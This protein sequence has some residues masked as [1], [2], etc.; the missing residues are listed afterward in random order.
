MGTFTQGGEPPASAVWLRAALASALP[1][2][3]EDG[4]RRGRDYRSQQQAGKDASWRESWQQVPEE[5]GNKFNSVSVCVCVRA[6]EGAH[7]GWGSPAELPLPV[8]VH[9]RRAESWI[10][11]AQHVVNI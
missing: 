6:G 4:E 3:A 10:T 1:T 5:R 8:Q 11:A 2:W 9:E 7:G